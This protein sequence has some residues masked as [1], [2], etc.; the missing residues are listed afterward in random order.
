MPRLDKLFEPITIRTMT[1][2]NRIVMPPMV[3]NYATAGGEVSQRFID[4]VA[5]R[6]RG[7]VGLII[8]EASYIR[9]DG[10]GFANQLGIHRDELVPGLRQLVE[11]VHAEGARIAIQLFHAGRQ[12]VSALTGS[13]PLAPSP[14]PDPTI[15]EMPRA[16]TI[17]EIAEIKG[18]Y[19]AAARRAKAAG[20][21]AVEIH[22]A[23]GYLIAAFLSP[24]SNR[25]TDA[26]GGSTY[27]RARFAVEIVEQ[28]RQEVGPD[29][30]VLFRMS[31]EE[32]VG[33]GLTLDQTRI[34]ARLLEEAGVDA[35]D[36]SVGTYATPGSQMIPPLDLDRGLLAPLATAIKGAVGI[37]V[38]AVGRLNDPLL[39]EWLIDTG[40]T[41]LVAVGR[42]L[43]ADPEW[44]AKAQRGRMEEIRPCIACNQA[45]ISQ[46]FVQQAIGCTVNP[47]C[48]REAEFRDRPSV[49][50]KDIVVVGG[51]P[52]GLES[53]RM[54]AGR[55][56]RVRLFEEGASLGGSF[57]AA[58]MVPKKEEFSDYLRWLRDQAEKLGVEFQ[59]GSR[60]TAKA[61]EALNPSAVIVATGG[62]PLV[63]DLPGID[64]DRVVYAA[65]V[66]LG[67]RPVGNNVIVLGGGP[68]GLEV[69]E[70]LAVQLKQVTLVEMTQHLGWGM[71]TGHRYWLMAT[72]REHSTRLLP[73]VEVEAVEPGGVVRVRRSGEVSLLGPFDNIVIALGYKPNRAL[74]D[75]LQGRV[76]ETY[77]V[78]DASEPRTAVEAIREAAEVALK[79]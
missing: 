63:P 69:A 28:V 56:H 1:L 29:Y 46:L 32:R 72:L 43:L 75:E 78:G 13:Q 24:F 52:A 42:G 76:L 61:V 67:I 8:L 4:Y 48:G 6:A 57:A 20:F 31:G 34:I 41:D 30:P 19:V 11:A 68:V 60:M 36:V 47:A 33:G 16:L 49:V 70:Y 5:A 39:A 65:D 2:R 9:S 37:P 21:D 64:S 45:C 38:I 35:L 3:T 44:V 51:G 40:A 77:L 62:T 23:H 26:Y 79:V 54:L 74:F 18:D 66:L 22:G 59:T 15:K 17:D 27:R 71:E 7:G 10:R 50:T 12:T 73:D 53:A 58:A 14:I 55:G 25:R